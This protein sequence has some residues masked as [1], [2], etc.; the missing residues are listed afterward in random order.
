MQFQILTAS[1]NKSRNCTFNPG[2]V[3]V[4][5]VIDEAA[6][7][8]PVLRSPHESSQNQYATFIFTSETCEETNDVRWGSESD[9]GGD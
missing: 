4:G 3:R 5:I 6:I 1:L 8:Q 2:P 9:T 7:R